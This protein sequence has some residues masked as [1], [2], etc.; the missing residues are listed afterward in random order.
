MKARAVFL[1]RDGVLNRAVVR[2]GKPYPP[3]DISE[4]E[5]FPGAAERLRALKAAGFGLF[6]ITNQ[7]DVARNT[8]SREAVDEINQHLLAS[9]DL[10]EILTCFHDDSDNCDCRKP[11][12]GFFY[13]V[14]NERAIDLAASYM[15]GD[16][17][18]DILAGQNA[19]CRTIFIDHGYLERK[20]EPEADFVCQSLDEAVTWILAQEKSEERNVS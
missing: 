3:K 11:L 19:G 2:D 7:P 9:I 16:R 6:V 20:P 8:T 12:P 18:R 13:K 14:R 10:D 4:L 5:I 17:W 15:I 1:D